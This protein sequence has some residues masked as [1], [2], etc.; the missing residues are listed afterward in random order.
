MTDWNL[1]PDEIQRRSF[2]IID[3]EAPPHQ[4]D[5]ACW[6]II[7]R[8]I[9]T[10]GDFEFVHITRIHPQALARGM[11]AIRAGAPIYTDTNM[12]RAG[13]S[14]ALLEPFGVEV[15]CLMNHPAAAEQAR[16]SGTTR[17]V[18]AVD[19]A[20]DELEGAIYVVGNAPTALYRL[21]EHIQAGKARPAL[22]VGLPVGFVNAAE[23]K[24]A[25][26]R[27][28]Q[29]YITVSGRKGGS[30]LAAAVINA[31]AQLCR[32]EMEHA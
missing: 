5:P 27:S 21:L 13:I 12:A 30:A 23:S 22:V 18:A 26:A 7:R 15:R 31:L 28:D 19:L 4:W 16:R 1:P 11:E 25:L 9:H 20:L 8:M 17:A 24:E 2:A 10:S 32:E 14:T 6:S 29:P 3:W